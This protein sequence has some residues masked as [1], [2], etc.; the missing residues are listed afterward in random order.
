MY[1]NETIAS[2][3]R[4]ITA[5]KLQIELLGKVDQYKSG[6]ASTY[7]FAGAELLKCNKDRF[8]GSGVIIS[9]KGLSGKELVMPFMIKNGLSNETINALLDDMQKSYD[10]IIELKPQQKRLK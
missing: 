5:L 2:L 1:E 7:H 3:E 10:D 8:N 9:M 6:A 4:E